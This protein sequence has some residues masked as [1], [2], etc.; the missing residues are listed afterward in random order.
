MKL[1]LSQL[2]SQDLE[3]LFENS[4]LKQ[5]YFFPRKVPSFFPFKKESFQLKEQ[6]E[7]DEPNEIHL[8]KD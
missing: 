7:R 5:Q 4:S 2:T 6:S 8:E 1:P 3:K